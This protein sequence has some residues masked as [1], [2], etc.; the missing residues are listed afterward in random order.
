MQHDLGSTS[1]GAVERHEVEDGL[2]RVEAKVVM[3]AV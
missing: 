2:G 3:K 1:K